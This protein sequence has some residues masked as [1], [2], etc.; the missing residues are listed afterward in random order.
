MSPFSTCCLGCKT[1]ENLCEYVYFYVDFKSSS[2]IGLA[3]SKSALRF[4][5]FKTA[6]RTFSYSPGFPRFAFLTI[7]SYFST[8]NL[9]IFRNS[10]GSR[11]TVRLFSSTYYERERSIILEKKNQANNKENSRKMYLSRGE[12]RSFHRY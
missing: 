4:D 2:S 3:I 7:F 11:M 1:A 8:T 12:C 9:Q 10:S 5:S 6:L